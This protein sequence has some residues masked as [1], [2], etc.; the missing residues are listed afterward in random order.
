MDDR[1]P[2]Y[3]ASLDN[4]LQRNSLD[5]G[6]IEVDGKVDFDFR[7]LS[8]VISGLSEHH[9][10]HSD[11][12][13][14]RP[15]NGSTGNDPSTYPQL[16]IVMHVVGSR[17]DV[18]PFVAL[19]L[20]LK[21]FGHRIRLATHAVFKGFVEGYGIEFFS[22]SGDPAELMA[23]MVKNPGIIPKMESM[24]GDV[25]EK[26][27]K[28]IS[29]ILDG[30]WRSCFRLCDCSD[31]Q[32]SI[33][34]GA[35]SCVMKVP[36]IADVI[37]ANPP[38][39]A[40]IH[41]AE[42]LGIPLHIMFTMSWSP[43]RHFPHP[44]VNL[45]GAE[46]EP[47][48]S[49]YLSYKFLDWITWQG[50]GREINNFRSRCL[51]LERLDTMSAISMIRRAEVP[52]TYC[53]SEKLLQRPEDWPSNTSVAGFYVLPRVSDF[54]PSEAL[55]TFL[56]SGPSPIYI[57]FG[58]IVIDDPETFTHTILEAVRISG[59]R[60]VISEGWGGIG[61]QR[62]HHSPNIFMLDD[63]PH[64]WLFPKVQCVVHHGGAGTTSAG[65]AAG[66]PTIIVPFFG[67]QLTWGQ[68]VFKAGAGPRPLPWKSLTPTLLAEAI[69]FALNP[70]TVAVA[71]SIAAELSREDG[72]AKGAESLL[73]NVPK[74]SLRCALL[75]DKKA[76][77]EI[78]HSDLRLSAAAAELLRLDGCLDFRHLKPTFADLDGSLRTKEY[79]LRT[80][81]WDPV[82]GGSKAIINLFYDTFKGFAEIGSDFTRK[83]YFGQD[84][85]V[86]IGQSSQADMEAVVDECDAIKTE[87]SA[88][89]VFGVRIAKG[90]GRI[91]QAAA[92]APMKFTVAMAEGA[93]NAPRLWGDR[94]VRKPV[95]V[96][97]IM[98][99]IS[100]GCQEL[101]LGTY[102]GIT[103]L[104]TLPVRGAKEQGMIG[105]AKGIGQG[106]VG[107]PV[108]FWA[109]MSGI[110][111]YPMQGVDEQIKKAFLHDD[112][113]DI[114][115]SLEQ[116]GRSEHANLS[117]D[118]KAYIRNAW[119]T[120]QSQ[121]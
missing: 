92:R 113:R 94:S 105:F 69:S 22:I 97:G 11:T 67:D 44:L 27:T 25:I 75:S 24:R 16:N 21:E 20:K 15:K 117:D 102:D 55:T 43:T 108:K 106:I 109:G 7:R 80:Y 104:V 64:D 63:C 65:L 99:G 10:E 8:R 83:P 118:E 78:A 96:T 29:K 115:S 116:L 33:P 91:F 1:P 68:A 18:Q 114:R 36:F 66:K 46:A 81:P 93:H 73:A 76:V 37:I 82:S 71:E 51:G 26:Q 56:S 88:R 98:S 120:K 32:K 30:C 95:K 54:K 13:S 14:S 5:R 47:E 100:A 53:W 119:A 2:S 12:Q 86:N 90:F 41:C 6:S 89:Q 121:K 77:W 101:L 35:R 39:F 50:L 79:R 58:S 42:K 4:S 103:G 34:C 52:H 59:V 17:G 49:N 61:A 57:G 72:T 111:G 3:D 31:N 48:L 87:S 110:T 19:A 85:V 74:S 28:A 40:H 60:A 62:F 9:L 70:R 23:Y 84:S 45:R 38:S 112:M 107:M